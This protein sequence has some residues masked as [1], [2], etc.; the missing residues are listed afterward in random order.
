MHGQSKLSKV[1]FK[2][3]LNLAVLLFRC[4]NADLEII[5]LECLS[6]KSIVSGRP[7]GSLCQE[8]KN[9]INS[10]LSSKIQQYASYTLQGF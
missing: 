9:A 4:R 2:V 1:H 10:K 3:K 7:N 6:S 8:R 5:R